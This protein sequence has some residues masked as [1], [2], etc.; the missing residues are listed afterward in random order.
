MSWCATSLWGVSDVDLKSHWEEVFKT[1]K[2][3]EVS[4]FQPHLGLSMQLIA[5][6][7]VSAISPVIDVGGGDSTLV[8]DLLAQGV[9]D[10]SVLDISPE[11]LAR[12]RRRLGPRAERV[13]W[14]AADVTKAQLPPSHYDLWHDRAAFHFLTNPAD[15]GAYLE[16]LGHAIRPSGHVVIATFAPD[17]PERCSGLPIVRYS[18]ESLQAELGPRYELIATEHEAH[19]TPSGSEQRFVYCLFKAL[20]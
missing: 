11:A 14:I 20:D 3:D 4:W 13:T 8:D 6:A 16:V 19:Q 2:A 9:V 15:R 5:R 10:V 1:K 12:A 18:P 17:G 7:G